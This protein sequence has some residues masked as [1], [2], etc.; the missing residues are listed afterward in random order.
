MKLFGMLLLALPVMAQDISEAEWP[1]GTEGG[2]EIARVHCL[3][4]GIG[5]N[6]LIVFEFEQ[7][8]EDVTFPVVCRELLKYLEIRDKAAL[9]T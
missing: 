4:P 1:K 7:D 9:Q 5:G 3:R 6:D 2:L 8:G